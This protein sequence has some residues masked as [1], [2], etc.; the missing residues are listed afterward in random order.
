MPRI[1]SEVH[2][3]CAFVGNNRSGTSLLGALLDAHPEIAM[4]HQDNLFRGGDQAGELAWEEQK[5]LFKRLVKKSR[6]QAKIGRTATRRRQGEGKAGRYVVSYAVP[7]QFQG[8]QTKLKVIGTKHASETV[9][10]WICNER[11]LDDLQELVGVDLK[12]I[13][14]IRNPFDTIASMA[15]D[16]NIKTRMKAVNLF[17][18]RSVGAREIRERGYDVLDTYLED[19]IAEPEAELRRVC[20]FLGVEPSE[21]YLRD[22]AS[23]V[24]DEPN[25]VRLQ[26]EWMSEELEVLEPSLRAFPWLERYPPLEVASPVPA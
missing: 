20:E 13:H 5:V 6:G 1:A 16:T 26:R 11:A 25:E 18:L 21:E 12:L 10:A 7:N 4:P 24:E 2:A 3:F 14:Q 22:C 15:R 19:L 23:V 8:R 9:D 17:I